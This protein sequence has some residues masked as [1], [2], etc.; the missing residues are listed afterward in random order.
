MYFVD[1]QIFC[2]QPHG[3]VSRYWFELLRE[4][5]S[6]A[7]GLIHVFAGLHLSQMPL[8]DLVPNL[9]LYG[10]KMPFSPARGRRPIKSVSGLLCQRAMARLQP[11]VY[12]ATY[13]DVLRTPPGTR[14][15]ITV[16]DLI[17]E[18]FFGLDHPASVAKKRS[19]Q[20][21][22][23]VI[24][25]SHATRNDLLYYFPWLEER[26]SVVHHGVRVF[27]KP[28]SKRVIDAPYL[29]YVG[30]RS[31]YKNF[32]V[33]VDALEQVSASG[34]S[35][36][37]LICF[38]GGRFTRTE[39]ESLGKVS[40]SVRF[41]QLSGD[42]KLLARLYQD[43]LALVYPSLYE[44]FGLPLL[45]AMQCNCPVICSRTS[46]LPEVAGPAAI[47]FDPA[48]AEEL[49]GHL[50]SLIQSPNLG[51][52]YRQLGKKRLD[53]FSWSKAATSTLSVYRSLE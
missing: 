50:I 43:A 3:G 7:Q 29:L 46:S 38:G 15:V 44:G 48:S 47:Y 4:M 30:T 39:R 26:S 53:Y 19:L 41:M 13:Y 31:G 5:G 8:R 20:L 52:M 45:E 6:Q 22:D 1:H 51:S 27:P 40:P 37:N 49:S 10:V 33:L 25:V 35:G 18:K 36:L 32:T 24:C 34:F 17:H 11:K 12:H 16:H 28:E 42:D 21:A 2:M 23:E 14:R 9:H